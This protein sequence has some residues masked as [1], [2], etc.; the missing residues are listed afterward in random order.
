[1]AN[2][3]TGQPCTAAPPQA[4][5]A[6]ANGEVAIELLGSCWTSP[7]PNA[8]GQTTAL[9][10]DSFRDPQAVLVVNRGETLT[11]RFA[12]AGVPTRVSLERGDQS[13]P[14]TAGNPTRFGSDL[15]AGVYIVRFFTAWL[16]G[17]AAYHVRLD[18]RAPA[19]PA[20]PTTGNIT[21]TG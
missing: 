18:V 7:T 6:G 1:M 16:Q 9:C 8:Q 13:T 10:V 15:P 2:R 5:L 14:L 21:L 11:L 12:T 3:C 20:T 17:D 4:S 19:G